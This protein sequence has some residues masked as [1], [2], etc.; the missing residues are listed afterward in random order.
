VSAPAR[1]SP[2]AGPREHLE[3]LRARGDRLHAH[4]DRLHAA[5]GD[6]LHAA[7][8]ADLVVAARWADL[9]R[10]HAEGRVL[11]E[12]DQRLHA[13]RERGVLDRAAHDRFYAA[14]AAHREALRRFR[15]Q[16]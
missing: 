14:L 11:H 6:H 2:P 15:T 4:W 9:D 12:E 8:P 3:Q 10:L 13:A 7:G 16:G 1:R 5:L